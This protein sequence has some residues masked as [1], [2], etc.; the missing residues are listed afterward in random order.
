MKSAQHRKSWTSAILQ[1]HGTRSHWRHCFFG[2]RTTSPISESSS[3]IEAVTAYA[4]C[5]SSPVLFLEICAF[6]YRIVAPAA[7]RPTSPSNITGAERNCGRGSQNAG[8]IESNIAHGMEMT[9]HKVGLTLA[10][11]KYFGYFF[12][13]GAWWPRGEKTDGD[14]VRE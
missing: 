7:V 13:S 14:V 6:S 3:C 12:S 11:Q 2:S 1:W 4:H 9:T 10:I 8:K 5:L